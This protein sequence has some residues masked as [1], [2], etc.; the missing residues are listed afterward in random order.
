MLNVVKELK[1]HLISFPSAPK[2]H[3]HGT[4]QLNMDTLHV[5]VLDMA[6]GNQLQVSLLQQGNEHNDLQRSLQT[7]MIL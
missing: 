2:K 5:R 1:D 6:Q 7:T 4:L 3:D